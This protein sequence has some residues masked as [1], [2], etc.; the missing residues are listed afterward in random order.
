VLS[1]G[2]TWSLK[3]LVAFSQRD[4]VANGFLA[5][6]FGILTDLFCILSP[7]AARYGG[8]SALVAVRVLTGLAEVSV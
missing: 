7:V 2:V 4:L 3:Y 8:V 5:S 1:S 6:V